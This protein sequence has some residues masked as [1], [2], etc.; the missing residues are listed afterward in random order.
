MRPE[1]FEHDRAISPAVHA[2]DPRNAVPEMPRRSSG[3]G[4]QPECPPLKPTQK[5][6]EA[7]RWF[8][9]HEPVAWFDASAPSNVIRKRLRTHGL[10]EEAGSEP[11]SRTMP[12][13]VTQFRVSATGRE[14]LEKGAP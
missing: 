9:E 7:L 3:V 6:I 5:W 11:L 13:P 2:E 10:I 1:D 8:A 12:L 14:L 4:Q